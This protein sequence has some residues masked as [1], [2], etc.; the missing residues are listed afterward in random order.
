MMLRKHKEAATQVGIK[1]ENVIIS[2]N[3]SQKIELNKD[4][5]KIV[6]RS[7]KWS[8]IYLWR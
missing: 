7:S 6:S 8:C 5:C 4:S 2:E 1:P 3:G